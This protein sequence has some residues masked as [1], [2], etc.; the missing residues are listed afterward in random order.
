MRWGAVSA[1]RWSFTSAC[2]L[3][4]GQ[5]NEFTHDPDAIAALMVPVIE[6]PSRLR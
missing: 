1:P 6:A 4:N 3:L 5:W 2:I